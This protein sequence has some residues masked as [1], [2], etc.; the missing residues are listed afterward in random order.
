[1]TYLR[2]FFIAMTIGCLFLCGVPKIALAEDTSPQINPATVQTVQMHS[3]QLAGALMQKNSLDSK[4]IVGVLTKYLKK[5]PHVYGASFTLAPIAKNGGLIKF[6]P[7][8]YRNGKKFTAINLA[9]SYDYTRQ[10]WYAVPVNLKKPVWSKPYFDQG[11][12]NA[13]MVTYS[14][15]VYSDKEQTKL[16]GVVTNDVLITKK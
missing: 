16:A 13:W 6:A 12:G 9:Q 14:I 4:A 8:V 3:H 15:P 2:N 10:D 11:G 7:Y 1:M 5:N